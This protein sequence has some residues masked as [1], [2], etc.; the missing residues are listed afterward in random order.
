MGWR[1]VSGETVPECQT[2]LPQSPVW[3]TY[4]R[5]LLACRVKLAYRTR[6]QVIEYLFLVGLAKRGPFCM[7]LQIS[8][9]LTYGLFEFLLMNV[10][11]LGRRRC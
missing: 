4:G 2:S 3:S 1:R 10:E 8:S 7:F 11:N 9:Q 6:L 5:E